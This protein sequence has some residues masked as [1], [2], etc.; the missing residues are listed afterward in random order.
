MDYRIHSV[1]AYNGR[2][3]FPR[4]ANLFTVYLVGTDTVKAEDSCDASIILNHIS[5]AG[6]NVQHLSLWLLERDKVSSANI[7]MRQNENCNVHWWATLCTSGALLHTV[8]HKQ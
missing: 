1:T 8:T 6:A 2:N 5:K 7:K 4:S 3:Q